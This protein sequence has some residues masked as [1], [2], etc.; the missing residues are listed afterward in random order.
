MPV[1]ERRLSLFLSLAVLCCGLLLWQYA[2][3]PTVSHSP[4]GIP[5][6][7][8]EYQR[9]MGRDAATAHASGFPTPAEF[10]R[11]AM[12]ELRAPLRDNG[13]GD[14]GIGW[15]LGASLLRV[16]VGYGL[17]VLVAVPLGFAFGLHPVLQRAFNPFV[18]IL[19]PISPLAWMPVALY[20]IRNAEG[21]GIFVIFICSLW[22]ILLNT[23]F[24]VTTIRREWLNVART[25]E[26]RWP[27][28]LGLVL[29]PAAAPAIVTGMRIGL[30]VAWLAI[31]AAEMLVGSSGIGYFVWNQ[32]NNL[33]LSNV[34]LAILLIGA[35]GMLLDSVLA[36]VQR[37]VRYAE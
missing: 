14:R 30:G 4:Y 15:Q 26:V 31:V 7:N 21:C 29:L 8:A 3:H 9:L 33:S 28:R 16:A 1:Q 25:L 24:G 19:R 22:P 13:P 20:T 27:Q 11:S 36:L 18:Q 10:V 37:S 35:T 5:E 12:D 23:S 6:G 17:A 32:W 2:T 34:I